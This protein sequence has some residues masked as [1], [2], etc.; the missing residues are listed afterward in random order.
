MTQALFGKRARLRRAPAGRALAAG[1]AVAALAATNS[2]AQSITV[3]GDPGGE[4]CY[5]AASFGDTARSAL[6]DCDAAIETGAM[7]R[8]DLAATHV[9]RGIILAARGDLSSALADYV[10]ARRI[11]PGLPE[12]YIGEGNTL[13]LMGDFNG[14][15]SAYATALDNGLSAKHAAHFNR[16]LALEHMGRLDEAEAA[17]AQAAE[18]A[19]QW[20]QPRAHIER[21]HARRAAAEAAEAGT[22]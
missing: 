21:I 3:F 17:Y 22:Q 18:L 12:S 9:N 15:L 6:D 11:R 8:K 20:P 4:A 10:E 14:A 16:G 19:P 5:R 1:F 13:F 2:L 7:L